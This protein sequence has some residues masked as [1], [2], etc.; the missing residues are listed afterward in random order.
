MRTLYLTFAIICIM[1]CNGAISQ[2]TISK[3]LQQLVQKATDTAGINALVNYGIDLIHVD[4]AQAKKVFNIAL[5]RSN[6]MAYDYGIGSSYA[7]L[8]YLASHEGHHHESIEHT[9]KA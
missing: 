3:H 9:K 1:F 8:G 6:S 5:Q 4:N 2:D 7:R